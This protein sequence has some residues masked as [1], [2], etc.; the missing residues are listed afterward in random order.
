MM[1]DFGN[2]L[3]TTQGEFFCEKGSS[4]IEH[5]AE[6]E[7][8]RVDGVHPLKHAAFAVNTAKPPSRLSWTPS[9]NII[10][11]INKAI[12]QQCA[13]QSG[14]TASTSASAN[15]NRNTLANRL[16]NGVMTLSGGNAAALPKRCGDLTNNTFP[17]WTNSNWVAASR[18]FDDIRPMMNSNI[19]VPV[20]VSRGPRR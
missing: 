8:C 12:N 19:C 4:S 5:F 1:S 20:T 6:A 18:Q 3:Y 2:C 14:R 10:R 15:M 9:D 11:E 16:Y 17:L 13:L 7:Q